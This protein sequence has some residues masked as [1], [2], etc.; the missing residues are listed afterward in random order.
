MKSKFYA[1]PALSR[2]NTGKYK[3]KRTSKSIAAKKT[4]RNKKI[5]N[6]NK[7]AEELGAHVA[8]TAALVV[9]YAH[10]LR[11]YMDNILE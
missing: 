5:K 2:Y 4:Q 10:S 3:R 9:T 11:T 8:V 7:K 6:N 1:A